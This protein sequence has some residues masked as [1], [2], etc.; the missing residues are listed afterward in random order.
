LPPLTRDAQADE[1]TTDEQTTDEQTTDEQTLGQY[2]P[3]L[4]HY[5]M[6][7]DEDRV[8]A[9]RRAIELLVKPGMHVVELGGGTG[10]LSSFA[11]RRGAQVSCVERNPELVSAARRFVRGNGLRERIQVIH[12][13]AVD[14]VP[15]RPVDVVICEMLHV[16]LLREKQAQ[17]IAA[18]KRNYR[19]T[20]GP[21]RPVFVPE[22]SILMSQPVQHSFDFAG[23]HAPVPMFQAPLLD[24]PRTQPLAPLIPYA[25]IAYED[26]IPTR[27]EVCQSTR[28]TAD[29][30][31][32]AIRF[33]TQNVLAVDLDTQSA[34][35]W[36]NQ[37]LVLPIES[38]GEIRAGQDIEIQF[39]YLPGDSID[40]LLRSIKV[41]GK[42][43]LA[44]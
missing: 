31:F 22:V 8:G 30:T 43:V 15:D 4:Y 37:C 36:A 27:F 1:Q 38:P 42:F 16:G 20:Y 29:G 44:S 5:N 21:Q 19:Q 40:Q 32:N 6:L 41:N 13:D 7:Q 35:T 9:F 18:F 11:A 34:I 17:V 26:P 39:N 12:A 2:I 28:S 24:Q 10:I 23:Y 33:V 14:F 25:N 3:L